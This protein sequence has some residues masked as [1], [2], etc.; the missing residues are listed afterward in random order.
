MAKVNWEGE[1]PDGSGVQ[2]EPTQTSEQEP[3]YRSSFAGGGG[4]I[5][6]LKEFRSSNFKGNESGWILN[7]NGN[8][9]FNG[10]VS[11]STNFFKVFSARGI[12]FYVSD[13]TTPNGNLTG[14][15]GDL[16]LNGPSGQ[17]FKCTTGT[18]WVGL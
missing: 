2:T 8:A 5:I 17:P 7:R 3:A 13:G 6:P 10:S 18:T 14:S 1:M 11:T 15:Q 4:V 9:E 16:C 12:S